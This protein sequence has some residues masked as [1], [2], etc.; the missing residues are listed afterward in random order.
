MSAFSGSFKKNY[1][2]IA[3]LQYCIL[4]AL[5]Q[6]ESTIVYAYPLF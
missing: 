1:W 4:S 2:S 3:A 5:Q 6:S